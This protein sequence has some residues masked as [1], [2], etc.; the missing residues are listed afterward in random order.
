[1]VYMFN[2][3]SFTQVNS[4]AEARKVLEV[5]VK[6]TIRAKELGFFEIRLH[7]NSLQNLYQLILYPGYRVDTWLN[8]PEI[9]V[10]LR[11]SFREIITVS[12]LI[13]DDELVENELYERSEFHQRI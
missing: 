7:E 13:T 4:L 12:P 9:D 8:D 2:E 10:D 3:L 11:D 6:A 1:M 5:F